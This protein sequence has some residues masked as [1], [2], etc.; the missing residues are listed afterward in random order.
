[1]K[2]LTAIVCLCTTISYFCL[3]RLI[4]ALRG[5]KKPAHQH[6]YNVLIGSTYGD[7]I[8]EN[9]KAVEQ[10]LTAQPNMRMTVVCNEKAQHKDSVR[11]GSLASF[12]SYFEA[13]LVL[14][15]HS[16][17]DILPYAHRLG[18]LVNGFKKP[19]TVF[20]QHGVIGLKRDID[21][22][23]TLAQY[24]I[25][26][27]KI[28]DAMVVSSEFERD[29]VIEMGVK[30][31]KL[32]MSGL[33]RFDLLQTQPKNQPQDQ[34]QSNQEKK[35][36][37]VFLTWNKN[38]TE[39]EQK[40][41]SIQQ[42]IENSILSTHAITVKIRHHNMMQ[43]PEE[44][45]G[46]RQDD[47]KGSSL[48]ITDDSSLA[49][50]FIYLNKPVVFYKPATNWLISE[51]LSAKMAIVSDDVMLAKWLNKW[52][53]GDAVFADLQVFNKDKRNAFR[54]VTHCLKMIR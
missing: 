32:M 26:Q 16:L 13:D 53:Q 12:V 29:I 31:D 51:N 5:R 40:I 15:T 11:R 9:V 10:V 23:T 1:M 8:D 50:D 4:T 17:S 18:L 42:A 39:Y 14:Y 44:A 43:S 38:N 25:G 49:W 35:Q 24:I 27:D 33:P 19:Y 48:L 41:E 52:I 47:I 28:F 34:A 36:V 30:A 45:S 22:E 21:K 6:N 7:R 54:L 20:M 37:L 2:K 46:L 3:A